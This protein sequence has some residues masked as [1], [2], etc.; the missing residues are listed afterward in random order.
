VLEGPV[1]YVGAPWK[2]LKG[3]IA[4]AR[5]NPGKVRYGATAGLTSHFTM[6]TIEKAA[7]IKFL[8]VPFQGEPPRIAALA[9][10]HIDIISLGL[11]TGQEYAKA[12][13]FLQLGTFAEKRSKLFPNIPTLVEQG[14]AVTDDIEVRGFFAPKGT[15]KDRIAFL[16]SAFKKTL[17]DPECIE[18]L[19]KVSQEPKYMDSEKYKD[20]YRKQ[21]ATIA[22]LAKELGINKR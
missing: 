11:H 6:A 3:L 15:P 19:H 7:N 20:F 16:D 1:I 9:G 2:D 10:H 5:E 8:L 22:T 13:K 14:L 4:Y 12:G 18:A 21:D 17:E